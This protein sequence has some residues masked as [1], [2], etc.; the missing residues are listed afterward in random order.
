MN[1]RSCNAAMSTAKDQLIAK[2]CICSSMNQAEYPNSNSRHHVI[3]THGIKDRG[4]SSLYQ[5]GKYNS[6]RTQW[7]FVKWLGK[8]SDTIRKN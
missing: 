1:G 4:N 6:C 8:N 7:G 5:R 2:I 3:Q